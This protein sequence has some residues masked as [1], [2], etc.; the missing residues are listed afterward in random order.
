MS[1]SEVHMRGS[2]SAV[3]LS[4]LLVSCDFSA[5]TKVLVDTGDTA[6]AGGGTGAAHGAGADQGAGEGGATGGSG[7]GDG[8]SDGGSDG[9]DIDPDLLD[10]DG[11]GVTVG[12][13]DCDDGDPAVYPGAADLCDQRDE[14]CD[15]EIDED[16]RYL[17]EYEDNDVSASDLGDLSGGGSV[18][19]DAWIDSANDVDRFIVETDD[20]SFSLWDMTIRLSNIPDGLTWR[21]L[22]ILPT[23]DVQEATG[24][25]SVT[26]EASDEAFVDDA[27]TWEVVVEA[28]D[29]GSCDTPY[30]LSIDFSG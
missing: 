20:S 10:E 30:L 5:S 4:T 21:L 1:T 23:G 7:V 28:V 8:G 26:I 3:V 17:D 12:E 19:V 25:G 18:S 2:L 11:D 29:D 22:V 16:A 24:A 9:G 15:G 14:D 6:T 13:G 27:G